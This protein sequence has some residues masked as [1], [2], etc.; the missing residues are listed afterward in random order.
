[1][2]ERFEDPTSVSLLL[3]ENLEVSGDVFFEKNVRIEGNVAISVPNGTPY[4]VKRGAVLRD[5]AYP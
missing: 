3:S 2:D 4:V 5:G 1:M